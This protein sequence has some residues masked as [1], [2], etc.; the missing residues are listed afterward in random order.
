MGSERE[1]WSMAENCPACGEELDALGAQNFC[2]Y[3]S[4]PIEI[5]ADRD[6]LRRNATGFL[7]HR[8]RK[9]L[10]DTI[11]GD[12]DHRSE[13]TVMEV[14]EA[15]RAALIDF[16][17]VDRWDAID[18]GELF[19]AG[20]SSDDSADDEELEELKLHL[21]SLHCVLSLVYNGLGADL[22]AAFLQDAMRIAGDADPDDDVDVVL[23]VNGKQ[24]NEPLEKL[25]SQE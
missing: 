15:I 19:F 21:F 18:E 3:C 7:E 20:V 2:G 8:T 13:Y 1:D 5:E 22:T 25:G 10:L 24:I 6:A 11:N 14:Q 17:L 12:R 16:R 4:E 9:M 23:F